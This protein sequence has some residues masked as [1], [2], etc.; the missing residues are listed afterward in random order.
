MKIVRGLQSEIYVPVTPKIIFTP[1]EKPLREMKIALV[2]AA[3]V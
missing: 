3:G 2:T 1:V